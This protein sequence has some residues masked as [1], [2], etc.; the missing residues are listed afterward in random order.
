[1]E[2]EPKQKREIRREFQP[3]NL[4][5]VV[6]IWKKNRK[7]L[8]PF[9]MSVAFHQEFNKYLFDVYELALAFFTKMNLNN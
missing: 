8:H 6:L 5:E 4:K 7:P 1:M 2:I 9:F 3:T